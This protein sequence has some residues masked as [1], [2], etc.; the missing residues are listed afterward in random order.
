[1][2]IKHVTVHQARDDQ[3]AGATYLD[4]RSVPEF[5]AG[6]PDPVREYDELKKAAAPR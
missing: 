1:M 3:R 2:T 6:H 4:V 5:Q